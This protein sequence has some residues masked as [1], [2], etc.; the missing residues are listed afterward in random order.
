[1]SHTLIQG[2][3]CDKRES[4]KETQNRMVRLNRLLWTKEQAKSKFDKATLGMTSNLYLLPSSIF[5]PGLY[6][7]FKEL[8]AD[9]IRLL[10]ISQSFLRSS[11]PS[12][13]RKKNVGILVWGNGIIFYIR[14]N[15]N[16]LSFHI[17]LIPYLSTGKSQTKTLL[18]K[19]LQ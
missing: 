17:F 9:P 13:T 15:Y 7:K 6:A 12:I 2:E 3:V 4:R 10:Q 14:N 19:N 1:M 5:L 11:L 18:G 8:G 16:S